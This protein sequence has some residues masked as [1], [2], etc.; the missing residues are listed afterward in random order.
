MS[1][2]APEQ[3]ALLEPGSNLFVALEY[4][5]GGVIITTLV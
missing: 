1:N 4:I 2:S 3:E 5:A